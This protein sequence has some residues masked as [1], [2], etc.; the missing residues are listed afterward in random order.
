MENERVVSGIQQVGIGVS[1]ANEAFTWYK[2]IFGFDIQVFAEAAEANLMQRYTGGQP[3]SRYAILALNMQG[4]GG[5]EIWQYVSRTPQPATEPL[6]WGKPGILCIKIRCRDVAAF[7]AFAQ[8]KGVNTVAAPVPNPLGKLHFYLYDPYGNI[9]DVVEDDYWF[10]DEGK[11]CGGV[12]GVAIG[13][14]HLEKSLHYY[15]HILPLH[16]AYHQSNSSANDFEGLPLATAHYGRA[17]LQS[18]AALAGAFSNLL[19]PFTIELVQSMPHQTGNRFDGRLWGDLGYIHLCFDIKG[20]D[21]HTKTCADSGY[22][23]TVDSGDF[24]MGDAAGRFSYNEDPDGT[25]L[26]YVETYKVPILKKLGWYFQLKNR[27]AHKALPNWM[28]KTLR[29]SRVK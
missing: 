17:I 1:N 2:S 7:Y 14:S 10:C 23:L 22:P 18:T 16:V 11:L 21:A 12:C 29:F 19:G 24:N 27:P 4:G 20:Y 9:F 26:E 6:V 15:T 5:L 3:H 25:W 28:V 8:Q 13:V